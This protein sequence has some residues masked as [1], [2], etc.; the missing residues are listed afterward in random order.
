M[1]IILA[2]H[3]DGRAAEP[4]DGTYLDDF[5]PSTGEVHARVPASE[6]ADVELAVDAA[7]RAFPSWS[8]TPAAERSRILVRLADALE[9]R[10]EDFVR[11]ESIDSAPSI[12]A[13]RIVVITLNCSARLP[14]PRASTL[15]CRMIRL[16]G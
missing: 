3:I 7:K 15:T 8:R 11:A 12:E 9:G 10:L 14:L 2:N 13:S 6:A 16:S 4:L 5:D 1:T